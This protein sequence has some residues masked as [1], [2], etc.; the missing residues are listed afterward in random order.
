M[1]DRDIA[2]LHRLF[3]ASGSVYTSQDFDLFSEVLSDAMSEIHP[4]KDEEAAL[5]NR[6]ATAIFRAAG[7]GDRD[8]LRLKRA[9]LKSLDGGSLRSSAG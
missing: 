6:M 1:T 8:P 5:R 7:G 2:S 9:A 3:G 4:P